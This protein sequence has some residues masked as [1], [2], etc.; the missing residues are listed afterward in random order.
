MVSSPPIKIGEGRDFSGPVGGLLH[1]EHMGGVR[2]RDY[3]FL[4][5]L[6]NV[7]PSL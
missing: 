7:G 2:I 3:Q 1:M 4:A 6:A 5:Q